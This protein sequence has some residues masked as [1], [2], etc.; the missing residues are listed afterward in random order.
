MESLVVAALP[1]DVPEQRSVASGA[2]AEGE[3]SD[4]AGGSVGWR[5]GMATSATRVVVLVV[6]T[7]ESDAAGRVVG[8]AGAHFSGGL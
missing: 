7:A 5:R 8:V 4:G 3:A 1:V 2:S 6:R